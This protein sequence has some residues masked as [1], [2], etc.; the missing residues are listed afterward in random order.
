MATP[1]SVVGRSNGIAVASF[2]FIHEVYRRRTP[3]WIRIEAIVVSWW[4]VAV[5]LR[6]GHACGV[7]RLIAAEEVIAARR[8]TTGGVFTTLSHRAPALR[9]AL[10]PRDA[11]LVS[12]AKRRVLWI[13]CS[14]AIPLAVIAGEE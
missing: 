12:I 1:A 11:V 10:C 9:E 3:V 14:K 4:D 6:E 13:L 7:P 8:V 2:I 5:V